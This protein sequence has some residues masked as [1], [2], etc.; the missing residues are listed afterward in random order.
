MK[1]KG[2]TCARPG[3]YCQGGLG[4]K[5]PKIII[6]EAPTC[7]SVAC[8]CMITSI[9]V[10]PEPGNSPQKALTQQS[11]GT[12]AQNQPQ[13]PASGSSPKSFGGAEGHQTE[14]LPEKRKHCLLFGRTFANITYLRARIERLCEAEEE[15]DSQ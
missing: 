7:S 4:V 8:A 10:S 6:K 11:S 2:K 15:K 12:P 9:E 5:N 3:G 13:P 14:H 1:M